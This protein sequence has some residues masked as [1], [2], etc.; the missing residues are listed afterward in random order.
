M[1]KVT[2]V[3][4]PLEFSEGAQR[5]A[6]AKYLGIKSEQ[7]L[8]FKII[9]KSIDARRKSEIVYICTYLVNLDNKKKPSGKYE[10]YV[11]PEKRQTNKLKKPIHVVIVGSGPSGLFAALELVKSGAKVTV[12]ERGQAVE[13]RV[14]TVEE[15]LSAGKFNPNSNIQFGEGGAGTFSDGK[16]NTGINSSLTKEVLETFVECGAPESILYENKPHI[17][18]D[19]LRAVVINL[20]EKIISLGGKFLFN[21]IFTGFE[22]T[23]NGL[24]ISHKINKKYAK[25]LCDVLILAIGYSARDTHRAM[26]KSGLDYR[27]K[28]FSLGYRIEHLQ[29]DI[30]KSQYGASAKLLPP[31]DYKLFV[32]LGDKTVYTFCM[33]P[34]GQVVPA[35]SEEC[36]IVT[37][38]M[39]N[40]DRSGE[41]ANSAILV[42]VEPREFGGPHPLAGIDL[43]EKLETEAY[44]KGNGKFIVTRVGDFMKGQ[45]T[46]TLGKVKPTIRPSYVLGDVS[47]LLPAYLNEYIKKGI[48]ELDKKLRGFADEYALLTG[49]ETRSSAPFMVTRS[50]E[51]MTNIE[52]VYA[53][54]EGAGQAGGIVSSAVDGMKIAI[55][56]V[57][58]YNG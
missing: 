32:H 52:N 45:P 11:A 6:I 42:S 29:E 19:R 55:K 13:E 3:K 16:L 7:V 22:K 34:G 10:E 56:I 38:G 36:Q 49:I 35:M 50:E 20:R 57:E 26:F 31:A 30:N 9:K 58:K 48:K 2:N 18:T 25:I 53:V 15:L 43:Q 24:V 40:H 12:L 39:S 51:M 1:L 37:N 5:N 27:Q 14:K 21:T 41:N 23:Q 4:V 47:E 46:K 17:G 33:C 44:R 8:S 54:G 28:P